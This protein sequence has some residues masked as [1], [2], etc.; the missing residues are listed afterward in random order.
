MTGAILQFVMAAAVIVVAGTALTRFAD[1]ISERTRFSGLMVG[2][3]LLAGA[4]SLPELA[5]DITAVRMG[6][7]DLAM[8]DLA[9]SSLFNLLILAVLDLTRYSHG[10]ML[11]RTSAAHALSGVTSIVL[12]AIVAIFIVLGPKLGGVTLWRLGLGSIVVL[13]AYLIG[14]R[15]IYHGQKAAALEEKPQESEPPSR[16]FIPGIHKLGLKGAVIGYCVA[17][18]VILVAAPFLTRAADQ[19]AEQTGLGRTFFGTVFVALCSST[20]EMVTTFSAVRMKAFDLAIGNIFGSN[21]MNMAVLF[22]LDLFHEGSLLAAVSPI[23]A[24]TAIC[25]IVVTCVVVLGQL[26]QVE[27]T[28]PFLEPDAWLTITL[29]VA[30][31]CGLFFLK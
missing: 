3:V 15:L 27:K 29:I 20:P 13:A 11:S 4:T 31:L 5:I 30:A 18:A 10:R 12:T 14:F 26:Y 22:P 7:V 6:A 17:A 2:S 1:K 24:Y 9:G 21:C 25:V 23:H 28:K 16:S 8:G 19:L